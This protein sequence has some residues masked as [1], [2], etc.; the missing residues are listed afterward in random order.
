M[1]MVA[2]GIRECVPETRKARGREA[3]EEVGSPEAT[4]DD[5]PL[6]CWLF[7]LLLSMICFLCARAN[8][9]HPPAP[10]WV[11]AYTWLVWL[12]QVGVACGGCGTVLALPTQ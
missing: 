12:C 9:P 7:A 5:V 6:P 2:L 11:D 10:H 4:L 1:L 3:G 8:A